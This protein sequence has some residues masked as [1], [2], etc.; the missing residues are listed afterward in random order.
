MS[1]RASVVVVAVAKRAMTRQKVVKRTKPPLRMLMPKAPAHQM[2]T[3]RQ[4]PVARQTAKVTT[5]SRASA[6]VVAVAVAAAIAGM[7]TTS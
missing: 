5:T 4:R 2:M 3:K 6:V 1:S 7:A